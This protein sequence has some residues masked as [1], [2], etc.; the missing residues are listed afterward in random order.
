MKTLF[1]SLLLLGM[2][3]TGTY[4][5]QA[6]QNPNYRESLDR[7][8]EVKDS[9]NL[10]QGTTVQRTYKAYD[11]MEERRDR[12]ERRRRLREEYYYG[13]GYYDRYFYG[14]AH[15][16]NWYDPWGYYRPWYYGGVRY[17]RGGIGL[18]LIW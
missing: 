10:S 9:V 7:Y 13:G 17:R 2:V 16:N 5:Q 15:Y 1:T 8:L 11:F 4:A 3:C 18:G 6:D 12:R 14:G